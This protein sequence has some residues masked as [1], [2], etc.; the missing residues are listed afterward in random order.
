ML[1]MISLT[2]SLLCLG[3]M[4]SSC[5]GTERSQEPERETAAHTPRATRLASVSGEHA[6]LSGGLRLLVHQEELLLAPPS[7]EDTTSFRPERIVALRDGH[8]DKGDLE[9]GETRSFLIPR[10]HKH[11]TQ[12]RQTLAQ[13]TV[14]KDLLESIDI[15]V[16]RELP[17]ETLMKVIHSSAMAGAIRPHLAITNKTGTKESTKAIRLHAPRLRVKR[18]RSST[19]KPELGAMIDPEEDE[20]SFGGPDIDPLSGKGATTATPKSPDT[21][22]AYLVEDAYN[23]TLDI[24]TSG[25]YAAIQLQAVEDFDLAAAQTKLKSVFA[26]SPCPL[27]SRDRPTGALGK[28]ND[29]TQLISELCTATKDSQLAIHVSADPWVSAEEFLQTIGAAQA[30]PCKV[31]PIAVWSGAGTT[32]TRDPTPGPWPA[33]KAR[34]ATPVK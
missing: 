17:Y 34:C 9:K 10:L 22:S 29:L 27:I 32:L 33:D 20:G 13:S 14:A 7:S 18:P 6:P 24:G 4:S 19:L 30:A 5:R 11:I 15:F 3:F 21:A 16:D 2:L 25:V 23:I 1:R 12:S 8:L 28:S 31:L 26:K